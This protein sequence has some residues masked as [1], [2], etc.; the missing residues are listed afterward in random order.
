MNKKLKLYVWENVLCDYTCGMV[1]VLA[2]DLEQAFDLIREKYD[3][4]Y[5]DDLAGVE[6]EIIEE[7]E[8]FAVYGGG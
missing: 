3:E 5:L 8:A 6:P 4:Y 1:C 2:F 7:P